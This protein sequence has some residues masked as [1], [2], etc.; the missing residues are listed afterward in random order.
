MD[1][2]MVRWSKTGPWMSERRIVKCSSLSDDSENTKMEQSKIL[3]IGHGS[4][5]EV[6]TGYLSGEVKQFWF[7]Y[8]VPHKN[9]RY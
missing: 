1:S 6:R 4:L 3:T 5:H 9:M 2:K 8:A 7:I